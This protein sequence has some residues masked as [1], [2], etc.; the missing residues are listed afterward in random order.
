MTKPTEEVILRLFWH[1]TR[2]AFVPRSRDEIINAMPKGQHNETARLLFDM[3]HRNAIRS[4]PGNNCR[5]TIYEIAE[6]SKA[7]VKSGPC[8]I[9]STNQKG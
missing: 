6:S 9:N 3:S 7:R 4:F 5:P 8:N 1:R 2:A